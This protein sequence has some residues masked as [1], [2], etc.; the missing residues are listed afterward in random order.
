MLLIAIKVEIGKQFV[1]ARS[2]S[3]HHDEGK[4][5]VRLISMDHLRTGAGAN[6]ATDCDLEA[7]KKGV[8]LM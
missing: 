7:V 3:I 2:V 5:A 4:A 8:V 6:Q 1:T